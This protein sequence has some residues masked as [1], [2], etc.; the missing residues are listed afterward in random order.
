MTLK[1]RQ[2]LDIQE[3]GYENFVKYEKNKAL[4]FCV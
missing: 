4:V 2:S 3:D 1:I